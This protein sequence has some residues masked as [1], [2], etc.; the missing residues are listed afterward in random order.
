M[1]RNLPLKQNGEDQELWNLMV[2][3]SN[4]GSAT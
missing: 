1:A 3:G 4:L 2:L